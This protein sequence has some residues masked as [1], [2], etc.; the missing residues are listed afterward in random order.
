ML[1]SELLF[2]VFIAFAGIQFMFYLL[3]M[4]ALGGYKSKRNQEAPNIDGISVVIS[5]KMNLRISKN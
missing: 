2:W 5:S 4:I 3:V 1:I